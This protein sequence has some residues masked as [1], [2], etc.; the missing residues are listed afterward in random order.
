MASAA[1]AIARVV[2]V[3]SRES[4]EMLSRKIE[5]GKMK[6]LVESKRRLN[7]NNAMKPGNGVG[8][9]EKNIGAGQAQFLV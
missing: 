3:G 5:L 7:K 9:G 2:D 1:A 8:I 6:Q 4:L